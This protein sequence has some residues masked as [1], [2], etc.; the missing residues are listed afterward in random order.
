MRHKV[1]RNKTDKKRQ[2]IN[3]QKKNKMIK[4]MTRNIKD[5]QT[6]KLPRIDTKLPRIDTNGA[7]P[8]Q[9]GARFKRAVTSAARL[10]LRFHLA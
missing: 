1:T 5:M 7:F 4:W 8:L 9:R 3:N 6:T 10:W 2:S